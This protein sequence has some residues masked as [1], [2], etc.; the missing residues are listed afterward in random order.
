MATNH[1]KLLDAADATGA[2]S[3]CKIADISQV[4]D[5]GLIL[6]SGLDSGE[7][8]RVDLQY[9]VDGGTTWIT[10][11][12]W[13]L[14]YAGGDLDDNF[15]YVVKNGERAF[16]LV[17]ANVISES[18]SDETITVWASFADVASDG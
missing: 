4:I 7:A 1:V 14:T 16:D 8:V 11:Y 6:S 15:H 13:N 2:G 3:A 18:V 9:S 12:S 10:F 5:F 17:R